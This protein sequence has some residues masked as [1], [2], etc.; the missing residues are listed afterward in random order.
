MIPAEFT[1]TN[2]WKLIAFMWNCIP[3]IVLSV[4]GLMII[5]YVTA[6]CLSN[7]IR[8]VKR[9]NP[10]NREIVYEGAE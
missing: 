1:V 8:F 2:V 4:V 5:L 7:L 9:M 6:W 3:I 10:S